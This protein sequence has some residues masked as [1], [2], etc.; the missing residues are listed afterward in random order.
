MDRIDRRRKILVSADYL[1]SSK[2]Q[3]PLLPFSKRVSK[4]LDHAILV[5]HSCA[6]SLHRTVEVMS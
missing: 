6:S 1:G 4:R 2:N 3:G 5:M